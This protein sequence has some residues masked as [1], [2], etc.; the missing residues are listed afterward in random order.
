MQP[1]AWNALVEQLRNCGVEFDAAL[2]DAE[3]RAT[4]TRFG[5]RFPPDLREFLQTALPRGSRFPDW[6]SGDGVN[7]R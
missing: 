1:N 2:T 5:F 4:E 3:V 7:R 6:R